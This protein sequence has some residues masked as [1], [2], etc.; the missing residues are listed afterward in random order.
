MHK[1]KLMAGILG[2]LVLMG[3]LILTSL[4]NNEAQA[5]D[6]PV[7]P[8]VSWWKSN[9]DKIVRHVDQHYQGR[10]DAYIDK[11]Q[12]YLNKMR[13]IFAENG[14]AIVKS[15][16]VKLKG[17]SLQRHIGNIEQRIS[18]TQCLK[19]KHGGRMVSDEGIIDGRNSN[20][21]GVLAVY[22]MA[23]QQVLYLASL[24]HNATSP[25]SYQE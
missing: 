15:R 11:W 10:W 12:V 17:Q 18:I 7:L 24:S 5:A 8:E 19:K 4:I 23:K 22:K 2:T 25:N 13:S 6:C 16:G 3:F 14:T 9:H 1:V 21:S 20:D